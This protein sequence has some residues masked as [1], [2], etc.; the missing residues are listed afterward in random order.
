MAKLAEQIGK[1]IGATSYMVY[2]MIVE[3]KGE[4]GCATVHNKDIAEALGL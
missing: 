2:R 1:K 3:R 4:S